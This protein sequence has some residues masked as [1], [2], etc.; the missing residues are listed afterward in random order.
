MSDTLE[1]PVSGVDAKDI[2]AVKV[3]L[4][5]TVIALSETT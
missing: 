3:T 2:S 1:T 4:I 5:K